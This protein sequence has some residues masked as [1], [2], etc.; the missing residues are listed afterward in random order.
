MGGELDVVHNLGRLLSKRDLNPCN[1][2][3][4]NLLVINNEQYGSPRQKSFS[5]MQIE[6]KHKYCKYL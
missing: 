3:I 4:A 5:Y 2:Y 6:E 1:C